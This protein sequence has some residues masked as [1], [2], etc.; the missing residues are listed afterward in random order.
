MIPVRSSA[1]AS[2]PER[3]ARVLLG[4]AYKPGLRVHLPESD[5]HAVG[6]GLNW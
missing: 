6:L 5:G 2:W 3:G 1:Q 4:S